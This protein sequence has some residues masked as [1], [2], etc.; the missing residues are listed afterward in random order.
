M[1]MEYI[2]IFHCKTLQNYPNLDF[3]F[4]NTIYHLATLMWA[5]VPKLKWHHKKAP[6]RCLLSEVWPAPIGVRLGA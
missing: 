2:N 1:D 5:V 4:E 3:W 6:V